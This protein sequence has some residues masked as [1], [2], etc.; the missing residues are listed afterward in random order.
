VN[1]LTLGGIC[2]DDLKN[3]ETPPSSLDRVKSRREA[4][5]KRLEAI[6]IANSPSFEG[7][8]VL[9]F[10]ETSGRK[11]GHADVWANGLASTIGKR[12]FSLDKKRT[13]LTWLLQLQRL[14][15]QNDGYKFLSRPEGRLLVGLL[16]LQEI[17]FGRNIGVS[18][19][20]KWEVR[21]AKQGSDP[22]VAPAPL[23]SPEPI[24][25]TII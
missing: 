14:Q 10:F 16:P 17:L 20:T 23:A 21:L 13:R 5:A 25:T 22:G 4:K 8:V 3:P 9:E 24:S 15:A 1:R 12:P 7:K 11:V 18:K 19:K 2:F 6:D